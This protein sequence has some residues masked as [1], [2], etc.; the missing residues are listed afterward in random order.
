MREHRQKGGDWRGFLQMIG[1]IGLPWLMILLA[2]AWE[3]G[4]SYVMLALP[5]TTAALMSGSLK[6]SALWDAVIYYIMYGVIGASDYFLAGVAANMAIRNARNKVWG[7]MLRIRTDYYDQH[8][9]TA[10]TSAV[11]NDLETAVKS[12]VNLIITLIPTLYYISAAIVM[13]GDYDALLMASVLVLLPVQ[14]IYM[15]V[16]SRWMYRTQAGIYGRIGALTGYLAERVRN[17]SLIKYYSN[18]DE[19]LKNGA[20]ACNDLYKANM[21]KV[22]VDC[23]DTG[24]STGIELLQNL[25]AILFGVILLQQGRIDIPQWVAFFLFSSKINNRFTELIAKWQTLKTV[26]GVAAR[27]AEIMAAPQ[28]QTERDARE[29][30]GAVSRSAASPAV[31]F[32]SVSFSYGEKQALNNVTFTVPAGTATAIVGECGSGKSTLLNLLERFYETDCG[33][34]LLGGEDVKSISLSELRSRFSYV[35]QDAGVFS[36]TVREALTYGIRRPISDEEL[37]EAAHGA[38]A[39]DFI[40][41]LPGGLNG[42]VA[43]DGQSL[44]GGQRKRL[45]LAREFLRDADVLLLDEP[46]SALDA[47]TARAVEAALFDMFRGKTILM[48]THDM[49]L[50]DRMDQVVVLKDGQL[51][52]HGTYASLLESCPLFQEMVRTRQTEV[53]Q[54]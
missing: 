52:G 20:R 3:M 15:V 40:Q 28:E 39:W 29:A 37:A 46:T 4:Y 13:I 7:G 1:K 44:S 26:Q 14:Y 54:V 2:F 12:L 33:Q 17:L 36:G 25:V 9:P 41:A 47:A 18:E 48:V 49:S 32:Q 19:E 45:V 50:L 31:S 23:A 51:A 6:T 30:D 38:G 42:W 24:I 53:E 10:L 21:K 43:A 8:A 22:R 34:I 5:T 16:V 27:T 11:T 35:Q